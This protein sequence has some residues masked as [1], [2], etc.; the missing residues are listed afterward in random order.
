MRNI[1]AICAL[2]VISVSLAMAQ[3]GPCPTSSWGTNPAQS[4]PATPGYGPTMQFPSA[5]TPSTGYSPTLPFGTGSVQSVGPNQPGMNG[6]QPGLN[7]PSL[8]N[9][10]GFY[11]PY[12]WGNF[13]SGFASPNLGPGAGAPV[14][15]GSSTYSQYLQERSQTRPQSSFPSFSNY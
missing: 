8:F 10:F 4:F 3:C 5:S 11:G 15:S 13:N 1:A 12:G 9:P 7:D 2:I 14:N 6:C